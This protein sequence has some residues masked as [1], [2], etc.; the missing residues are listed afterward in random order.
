MKKFILSIAFLFAG[1]VFADHM[2]VVSDSA[3]TGSITT[4]VQEAPVIDETIGLDLSADDDGDDV[5]VEESSSVTT[6][7]NPTASP[8]A[9]P[10]A[11]VAGPADGKNIKDSVVIK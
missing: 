9:S 3:V 5:V 1:I 6:D 8:A 7:E 4:G 10:E 2:D 11:V